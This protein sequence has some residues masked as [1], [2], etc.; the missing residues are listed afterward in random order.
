LTSIFL[1]P[2]YAP[3][4][5]TPEVAGASIDDALAFVRGLKGID[6]VGFD[7]V[8]V[9]PAY[10]HGQITAAAAA[11]LVYEFV[12]LVALAKKNKPAQK[13]C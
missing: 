4:T 12:T 13:R 11:N 3:G 1:D 9:L 2:I 10:D 6:F 8:E 5:G 7:L